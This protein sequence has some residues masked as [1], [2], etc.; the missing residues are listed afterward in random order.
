MKEL[1]STIKEL[2]RGDLPIEKALE[3]YQR[4]ITL[5][6]QGNKLLKEAEERMEKWRE[7]P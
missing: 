7:S 5:I 3:I 4:G 1:L 6:Q 2:E